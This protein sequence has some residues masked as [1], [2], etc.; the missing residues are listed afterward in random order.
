M[1]KLR[2]Y[3]IRHGETDWNAQGRFQG[4]K[5]IG[6][7]DEGTS[8]AQLTSKVASKIGKAVIWCS[9]LSRALHTAK[10]LAQKG[11]YEIFIE[12]NLIEIDH[13]KWEGLHAEEVKRFFPESFELWHKQPDKVQMPGGESLQEVQE[14]ALAALSKIKQNGEEQAI[15]ISHDAVLKC[16]LCHWLELPLSSFWRFRLANCSVSI[17][18]EENGQ[19]TIPMLGDICHL[20]KG[21]TWSIQ[22]G[23]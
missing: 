17:V 9:P 20:K 23:L 6:L 12:E 2:F 14:R 22:R 18:E 10:P 8:Q 4:R 13:G 16:L 21:W 1:K 15:I 7:N 5:D 11:G 3:L 19:V